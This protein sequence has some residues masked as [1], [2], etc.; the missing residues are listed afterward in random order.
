MNDVSEDLRSEIK[1]RIFD[2]GNLDGNVFNR[3]EIHIQHLMEHDS[4]PRYIMFLKM[5]S[6]VPDTRFGA[7][8]H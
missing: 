3:I 2:G 6:L 8:N 7:E 4:Y 5:N 1:L